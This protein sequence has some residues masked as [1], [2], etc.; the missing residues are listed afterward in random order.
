MIYV[1]DNFIDEE[2][3]KILNENLINFKEVK[4]PGKSFWVIEP[5][6]FC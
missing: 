5:E 2:L 6:K 3:F 4:T 1:K